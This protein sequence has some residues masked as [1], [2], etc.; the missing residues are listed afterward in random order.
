MS[1]LFRHSAYAI[2]ELQRLLEVR[3]LELAVQVMFVRDHP[4]GDALL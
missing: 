1:L 4:L 2:D 3:E